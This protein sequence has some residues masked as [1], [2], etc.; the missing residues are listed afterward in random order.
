MITATTVDD[1]LVPRLGPRP[2]VTAGHGCSAAAGMVVFTR[3]DVGLDL[4][5]PT[6]C[7]ALLI[8]GVGLGLVFAP[9]MN[10]ATLGVEPSRRRRRLGDGQ[11]QPAGRRL[12]RHRA[13]E[14]AGGE[15]DQ[16]LPVA[17]KRAGPGGRRR[18]PRC[19]ATRPRSG[20]RPAIF[21]IGA[22][23]S[24]VVLR[25]GAPQ[26]A[27]TGRAG[28][29]ALRRRG[30]RRGPPRRQRLSG[31]APPNAGRSAAGKVPWRRAHRVASSWPSAIIGASIQR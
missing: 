11:H 9:S 18:R 14:H 7:P 22:L 27:A 20:G 19:T 6:S 31:A 23:L 3:L 28:A 21:A 24:G 15:R 4:R 29:R 25:S 26:P 8:M 2:L 5:R 1:Q 13:A 12:D 16:R 30:G 10:N 17:G